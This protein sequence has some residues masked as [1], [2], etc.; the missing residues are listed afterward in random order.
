M[1]AKEL[2]RKGEDAAAAYVERCGM[3]MLERNWRCALGEVDL[4]ALDSGALVMF[5]VKT[6]RSTRTGVPEEAVGPKKQRKI[7]RLAEA[8]LQGMAEPPE[9]V[10]FDVISITLLTENRAVLRHHPAAFVVS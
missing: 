7:V 4:I 8:Y 10:R 2:G 5:E 9:L 3:R 6:R 1:D